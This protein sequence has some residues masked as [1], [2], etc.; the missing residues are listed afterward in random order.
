M[1][2]L[3][4]PLSL[5]L[6]AI[7]PSALAHG[8]E[9]KDIWAQLNLIN[10]NIFLIFAAAI[11]IAAIILSL[12]FAKKLKEHHKKIL[13]LA[14]ALPIVISTAYLS[15]T[16]VYLN[17]KS[18][19]H[20]PVH[21]HADYEIF[22]CGERHE[23]AKP[24]GL[25]NFVGSPTSHEHGDNRIHIEGVLL[26]LEQASLHEYFESIGG[27]F[28]GGTLGLPTEHGHKK[29]A[30]GDLCNSRPAKWYVFVNGKLKENAQDYIISPHATVP[31]G[32]DI[33]FVFS[34]TPLSEDGLIIVKVWGNS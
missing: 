23:L 31:P 9:E 7:M 1:A 11:F 15:A 6:L 21:W 19:S 30:N 10:P 25:K 28:D 18:E 2:T 14:I 24:E 13:F 34:D 17:A 33:K 22:A 20:G 4:K 3:R 27:E 16:T 29:W 32:D 8:A 5:L 26:K 12:L